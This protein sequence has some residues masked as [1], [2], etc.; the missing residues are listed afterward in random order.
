MWQPAQTHWCQRTKR[1]MRQALWLWHQQWRPQQ[2]RR[3]NPRGNRWRTS[4]TPSAE[5]RLR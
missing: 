2:H 1:L 3:P 4:Q 5:S